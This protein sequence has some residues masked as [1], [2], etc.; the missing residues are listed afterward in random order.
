M[1][2]R[3]W[4]SLARV[5]APVHTSTLRKIKEACDAELGR[6]RCKTQHR[7]CFSLSPHLLGMDA[8]SLRFFRASDLGSR[9]RRR[10]RNPGLQER[11]SIGRWS[12]TCCFSANARES[13]LKFWPPRVASM[14]DGGWTRGACQRRPITP[15]LSGLPL[16]Q[17]RE[18]PLQNSC[19]PSQGRNPDDRARWG[20][21]SKRNVGNQLVEFSVEVRCF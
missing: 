5:A 16:K 11:E 17:R 2:A 1:N 19:L 4:K 21:C 7:A 3:I 10:L 8:G 18:A 20:H 14:T 13:S 12:S 15:G 6:S 9:R